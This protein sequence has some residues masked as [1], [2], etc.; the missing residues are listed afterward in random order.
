MEADR[1]PRPFA[2]GGYISFWSG[3]YVAGCTLLAGLLL[4][5]E[6]EGL[7]LSVWASF[8]IA[9]FVYVLHRRRRATRSAMPSGR[10][11]YLTEHP[12]IQRFIMVGFCLQAAVATW[13]VHPL[14]LLLV[15]LAPAGALLYAAG[16]VGSQPR[17]RL[18]LKN[19]IVGCAIAAL[20]VVLVLPGIEIVP[21]DLLPVVFALC[22]IVMIDAMLCDIDDRAVDACTETRTF[23][24]WIGA[25]P[26]RMLAVGME[27]VAVLPLVVA[28]LVG[29]MPLGHGI[30]WAS[31]FILSMVVLQGVVRPAAWRDLIDLRLPV[32]VLLGWFILRTWSMPAT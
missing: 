3:C 1:Q 21:A 16:S 24:L 17:D 4:G 10:G 8:S 14:A 12:R 5:R 29:I 28:G 7:V 25:G 18:L 22:G 13:L 31:V 6:L 23:P 2:L 30:V 26:T 15:V 11:R 19:L 9:M 20:S 32:C 27:C